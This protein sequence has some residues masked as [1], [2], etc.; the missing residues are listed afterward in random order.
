MAAPLGNPQ[1]I[2]RIRRATPTL[3]AALIAG[4]V[5]TLAPRLFAIAYPPTAFY[6]N[7]DERDL[8]HSALDRLLGLPSICLAWP[9]TT[10]QQLVLAACAL[11]WL[12]HFEMIRGVPDLAERL[13][14][15]LSNTFRDPRHLISVTRVL[16]AALCST[17]PLLS[18]YIARRCHSR[19]FFAIAIAALVGFHPA[20]FYQS[21]TVAGDSVA[22]ALV[23]LSIALL[24][25]GEQPTPGDTAVAAFVF[26]AALASKITVAPC[27][28]F[29]VLVL[30]LIHGMAPL[31]RL[32][33][34]GAFAIVLLLGFAFWVP[35]TW[36]DPIRFAK[37]LVG[38]VNKPHS[39]FDLAAFARLALSANGRALTGGIVIVTAAAIWV[40]LRRRSAPATYAGAAVFA[41]ILITLPVALRATTAF[42]RYL[43]PGVSLA[44]VAAG[45]VCSQVTSRRGSAIVGV[46]LAVTFFDCTL[47]IVRAQA[48]LQPDDLA[49]AA[50]VAPSFGDVA[51]KFVPLA[52]IDLPKISISQSS[53][54][55]TAERARAMEAGPGIRSFIQARGISPGAAD[56]L[57]T[58]FNED[59]QSKGRHAVAAALTAPLPPKDTIIY[60][61]PNRD[62]FCDREPA[63]D[64]RLE[65]AITRASTSPQ[66]TAI[67]VRQV[68][69]ELG[70]PRWRGREAWFWYVVNQ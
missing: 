53:Y 22:V 66:P 50:D 28:A 70:E 24:M 51:V 49:A 17:A 14:R 10:I 2:S 37:A 47:S 54:R 27:L 1:E 63:V 26:S 39:A 58:D 40:T 25:R 12:A 15:Y 11:D 18:Y 6:F 30:A 8:V 33:R 64:L 41:L 45:V 19:R 7:L 9:S 59:E 68:T 55:R 56:V 44:V 42:P 67:L 21:I 62:T 4:Y 36:T 29:H 57:I 52:A 34:I 32:R 13:T 43:L 3:I 46:A 48:L 20:F 60:C 35:F 5:V 65:D 16:V 23:L 38:T 69:P 61:E 31:E